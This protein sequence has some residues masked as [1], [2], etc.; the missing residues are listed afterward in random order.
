MILQGGYLPVVKGML[1]RCRTRWTL[2]ARVGRTATPWRA[3]SARP[4]GARDVFNEA[5]QEEARVGQP[6]DEVSKEGERRSVAESVC[7]AVA[8]PGSKSRSVMFPRQSRLSSWLVERGKD[9]MSSECANGI[10]S[11]EGVGGLRDPSQEKASRRDT[12][13]RNGGG[14]ERKCASRTKTTKTRNWAGEGVEGKGDE[15]R[16][17]RQVFRWTQGGEMG[18]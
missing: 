13:A 7:G 16:R 1:A 15:G 8:E 12:M 5:V 4:V 9:V 6:R 17:G 10:A 18:G 11:L 2:G 14:C 3:S